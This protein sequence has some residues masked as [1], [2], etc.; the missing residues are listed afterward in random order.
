MGLPAKQIASWADQL[1]DFA[2]Q[3]LRFS[4]S[5]Y[6]KERYAKIQQVSIAMLTSATNWSSEQLIPL[7]ETLFT[8]TGPIMTGDGAII[9][10]AGQ[11]LLIQRSDNQMWAM[12]GGMLEVGE[13]PSE[14]VL[15][16]VFEETG[17]NCKVISLVGIFDSRF[18][19]T[20]Y[21]LQLYQVVFLCE[22]LNEINDV[23]APHQHESLDISW[24]NEKELPANIDPGHISRIGEAFRVWYGDLKPFFDTK[25]E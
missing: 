11:I 2:A 10:E 1:R 19:G 23:V 7:R 14:G 20:T 4:T 24:F 3:G 13:T 18:C 12:P 16:E 15:R 5:V 25:E 6:D 9:N 17:L 21:P 8:H 22:A